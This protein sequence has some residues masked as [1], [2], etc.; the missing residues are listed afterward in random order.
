V[1]WSL[2]MRRASEAASRWVVEKEL[3]EATDRKLFDAVTL[4]DQP[5][6][7]TFRAE[8]ERL[9]WHLYAR[10]PDAARI[11]SLE[12]LWSDVAAISDPSTAW[13]AL[14]ATMMRDPDFVSY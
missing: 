11:D 10:H 7:P 13:T 14:L 1:T 9:Y 8:I 12:S 2:M 3:E 4:T 5:G 6:D